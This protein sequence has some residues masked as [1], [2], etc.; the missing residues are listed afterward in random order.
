MKSM[1]YLLVAIA[2]TWLA[3]ACQKEGFITSPDASITLST[4]MVAFDTV[5]VSQGSVTQYFTIANPNSQKLRISSIALAGGSSSPYSININGQVGPQAGNFELAAGDSMYVFVKVTIDPN[6]QQN[7]FV[8]KD[9]V[10]VQYNGNTR[11]VQLEAYGQNAR[12]IQNDTIKTNTTWDARLPYVILKGLTVNPGATLTLQQ[13]VRVYCNATAPFIIHGTLL[14]NG[15]KYDSTRITFRGDRLDAGYA[16]LPGGWPGLI[17]SSLSS[18]SRLSYTN[19]LNAYQ[20]IS[21]GGGAAASPPRLTLNEC[22][23]H[24]AYDYGIFALNTS[25]SARNC[26]ISQCGNGGNPG[27]GGSNVI[28]TGGGNYRFE[29]CTISTYGN[30]YQNHK[31]GCL[32]ISNSYSGSNAALSAL[33]QNCI[34]YGEGGAAEDEVMTA[35]NQAA[36]F[37]VRMNHVLYKVMNDPTGV[38]FINSIKNTDPLFDTIN[39]SRQ[40]YNFRLRD[41]SPC[42]NRGMTLPITI[43]LDGNPRPVGTLPDIGCYEKQ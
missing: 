15:D 24:N 17:F 18:G 43:D 21:I 42:I 29:H 23:I 7:P 16:D 32:F 2:L 27:S 19:L 25:I 36:A 35:R 10:A 37:D 34:I 41:G 11:W 12:F 40:Q 14:A 38:V 28:L 1:R 4:G 31:N 20:A 8:V 33:F 39:V 26:L 9:S 22:T 5:F 6:N 13:G 3:T 30:L